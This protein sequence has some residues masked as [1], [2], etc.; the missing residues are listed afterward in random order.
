[1][2]D[3]YISA[4]GLSAIDSSTKQSISITVTHK[5]ENI[6]KLTSHNERLN[7]LEVILPSFSLEYMANLKHSIAKE[8]ACFL[9]EDW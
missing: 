7:A 1:M 4:N 2:E 8:I 5:F 9:Y 3:V 6:E